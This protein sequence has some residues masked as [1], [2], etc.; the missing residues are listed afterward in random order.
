MG[1]GGIGRAEVGYIWK[2]G[3]WR[4]KKTKLSLKNGKGWGLEE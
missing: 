3:G 1:V 2:K 4:Y